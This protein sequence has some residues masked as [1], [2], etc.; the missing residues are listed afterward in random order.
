MSLKSNFEQVQ[1]FHLIFDNGYKDSNIENKDRIFLRGKLLLEELVEVFDE[2]NL[3]IYMEH[4]SSNHSYA[5]RVA[6]K[7]DKNHKI[8]KAKVAKELAD[9]LYVTYGAGDTMD[10]PM[11]DVYAEVHRSNMSKLG[12]DGKPIRRE[13]GKI[14]KSELYKPADI[15]KIL[16][17][18]TKQGKSSNPVLIDDIQAIWL[19]PD[20]SDE[21]TDELKIIKDDLCGKWR[22][23]TEHHLVVHRLSDDTYWSLIYRTDKDG[24]YNNLRDGEL[25]DKDIHQVAPMKLF[26]TEYR[27][28]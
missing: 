4:N 28:V 5:P 18:T 6:F 17:A 26:T 12:R 2:L 22:H 24:E 11:D 1:D 7:Q 19:E 16:I 27:M 23:G 3:Q 15:N 25:T 8:D 10:I 14:L 9:L 20:I 21:L 13:D